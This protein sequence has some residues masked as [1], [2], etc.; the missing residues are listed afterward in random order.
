MVLIKLYTKWSLVGAKISTLAEILA[1]CQAL[2]D[3]L[4]TLPE[5]Y[6][7]LSLNRSWDHHAADFA[8]NCF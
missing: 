5:V 2:P 7:P 4:A 3:F 1:P 8:E 6:A